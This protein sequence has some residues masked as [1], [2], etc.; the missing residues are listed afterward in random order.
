[1][2]VSLHARRSG[3]GA[4][5]LLL[6]GLFGAGTNLGALGRSLRDR[7]AV[8]AID[9][10]G[11][12][13]SARLETYTLSTMAGAVRGWLDHEGMDSVHL[14]GHSLG[15]KVAMQLALAAPGSVRSL[16]VADIAPV[17]YPPRHDAVFAA[18]Q[19]VADADCDS[20]AAAQAILQAQLVEPG[21][22]EFLLGSLARDH[23]GVYDW[24]FDLPGLRA[25]YAALSAAPAANGPWEGAV[26]FIKGEQSDYLR[27]EHR[28]DIDA[29]FP[30]SQLRVMAGCGHWLHVEKPQLFNGI[31]GRFLDA[32]EPC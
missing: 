13:R 19:S 25:G 12:G 27:E 23:R 16:V 28:A 9:L 21:V 15:G 7:Y 22:V 11:H 17:A 5:L 8:Y 32:Q 18:L 30:H 14:V 4:P 6:H 3:E 24:R 10:P 29:L 1:M 26:L 31:A 20:R 2:A